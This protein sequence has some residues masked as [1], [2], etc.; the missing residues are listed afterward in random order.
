MEVGPMVNQPWQSG[1]KY[2]SGGSYYISNQNAWTLLN[3]PYT[4]AYQPPG[5]VNARTI[6]LNGDQ[7]A[8]VLGGSYM[9]TIFGQLYLHSDLI[10]PGN[11]KIGIQTDNPQ[12]PLH[13]KE[14]IGYPYT[15]I[16]EAESN[17]ATIKLQ[18]SVGAGAVSYVNNNL[19]NAAASNIICVTNDTAITTTNA[20]GFL[21]FTDTVSNLGTYSL[22]WR[23]AYVKNYFGKWQGDAITTSYGGTG[24]T[25]MTP[26]SVVAA[27]TTSTGPLQQ[28]SGLG[29]TGQVLTSN[30][31][32]TLPTWQNVSSSSSNAWD[33]SGNN[34]TAGA[35]FLGTINNTSLRIRTNNT[36]KMIIDSIGKIGMGI[37]TPSSYLHL[38]PSSTLSD[39]TSVYK[40]SANTGYGPI[41]LYNL[42]A[43]GG[44]T[45]ANKFGTTVAAFNVISGFYDFNTP[46]RALNGIRVS[47]SVTATSITGVNWDYNKIILD[48]PWTMTYEATG[49]GGS[50]YTAHKFTLASTM[51]GTN[52]NLATFDNYGSSLFT[53]KKDGATSIG[54]SNPDASAKLDV[55]STTKGFLPPRMTK[56]QRDAI[57][58]PA[59][60]LIIY[61]TND[62]KLNVFTGS[63]WEEINSF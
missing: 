63:A 30:G 49:D 7:A 55:S 26:Y 22:M 47:G 3:S 2:F 40:I 62:H 29:T 37:S 51:T 44:F 58:S 6:V 60:G 57:S 52:S 39:A 38:S 34:I 12:A 18:N 23:N 24:L 33:I 10:L 61:N 8:G 14:P 25:S 4:E 45:L 5:I 31:T 28:I 48:N 43:D 16:F 32:G 59:E 41:D 53:I 13:V 9:H 1:R 42:S 19:V 15:A 11:N 17:F 56:T 35:N 20:T 36:E 21:P 46:V 54:A 50:D 27:G